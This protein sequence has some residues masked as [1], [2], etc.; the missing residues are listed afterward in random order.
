MKKE[1]LEKM[2]HDPDIDPTSWMCTALLEYAHNHYNELVADE[3]SRPYIFEAMENAN[4]TSV[5]KAVVTAYKENP[6]VQ[7]I[8]GF[9]QAV[10]KME[11]NWNIGR[12][13]RQLEQIANSKTIS[14]IMRIQD[15][16][17]E[18]IHMSLLNY[19]QICD[20]FNRWR[21]NWSSQWT[22]EAMFDRLSFEQIKT[23][24][25]GKIKTAF[26]ENYDQDW[27][28]T[29]QAILWYLFI[30][31][32]NHELQ[33]WN[34]FLDLLDLRYVYGGDRMNMYASKA[35]I[36]KKNTFG[37]IR[38]DELMC[39]CGFIACRASGLSFHQNRSDD[40]DCPRVNI[41]TAAKIA[42]VAHKPGSLTCTGCGKTLKSK[43]GYT[44][45][46]KKCKGNLLEDIAMQRDLERARERGRTSANIA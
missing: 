22:W 46:R 25:E 11:F 27:P 32:P 40:H 4:L 5:A 14:S 29:L 9:I 24:L 12:V 8:D 31:V 3:V 19:E 1:I 34:D 37:S 26:E 13:F 10:N 18:P 21:I 36:N 28:K 33:W 43:P 23:L 38:V 16:R 15:P 17:E 30:R 44:L 45:H 20:V 39:R 41:R 42:L 6:D 2:F 35:M 7:M